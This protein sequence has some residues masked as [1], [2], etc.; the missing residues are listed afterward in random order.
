MSALNLSIIQ[1]T[2]NLFLFRLSHARTKYGLHIS[3]NRLGDFFNVYDLDPFIITSINALV[4]HHIYYTLSILVFC[5]QLGIVNCYKFRIHFKLH[6]KNYWN[7]YETGIIRHRQNLDN[8]WALKFLG[9][10]SL[11]FGSRRDKGKIYLSSRSRTRKLFLY[12]KDCTI[13]RYSKNDYVYIW[14]EYHFGKKQFLKILNE[15]WFP[16]P[17]SKIIKWEITNRPVTVVRSDYLRRAHK[18]DT[19]I[20]IQ[21]AVMYCT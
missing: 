4:F 5:C 13:S 7:D 14:L 1:W 18:R 2:R 20:E 15:L 10:G 12:K 11:T 21:W 9:R 8:R 6:D 16:L 3:S 17:L 19:S